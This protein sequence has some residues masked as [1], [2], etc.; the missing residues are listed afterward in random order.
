MS[1]DHPT[2]KRCGR[3]KE[4][5][6]AE[7]FGK[8]KGKIRSY[9][10]GCHNASM[11]NPDTRREKRCSCCREVKKV[12]LFGRCGARYQSHCKDCVISNSKARN[13]RRRETGEAT[14]DYR[15]YYWTKRKWVRLKSKYGVTQEQY[16]EVFRNQGG[17]CAICLRP[18]GDQYRGMII[19]LC[20]DHDHETGKFRGLLCRLCN[21]GIGRLGESAVTLRRAAEYI[22]LN[23]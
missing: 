16:T 13:S 12:G 14:S 21:I 1:E 18:E 17:V 8:V 10:R 6:N 15:E 4:F 3:C 2:Q 7:F 11:M 20:V 23:S 19:N 9:C 22:E 5:K